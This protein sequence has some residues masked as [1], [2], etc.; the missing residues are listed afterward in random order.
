MLDGFFYGR[1]RLFA[2]T[3]NSILA[4]AYAARDVDLTNYFITNF[5]RPFDYYRYDHVTGSLYADGLP[6]PPRRYKDPKPGNIK[7]STSLDTK[8]YKQTN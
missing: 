3:Q 4:G 1:D 7:F 5:V 6:Y 2:A 8:G